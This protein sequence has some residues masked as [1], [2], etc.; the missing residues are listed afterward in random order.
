MSSGPLNQLQ[1]QRLSQQSNQQQQMQMQM[2][3]QLAQMQQVR[4]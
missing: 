2:Q 4:N 1:V 3:A